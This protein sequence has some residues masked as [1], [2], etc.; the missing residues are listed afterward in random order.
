VTRDDDFIGQLEGYLDDFEGMTPLPERVRNAIRAHLP[1]TQQVGSLPGAVR[2]LIMNMS[3]LRRARYALVA[4]AVVAAAVLGTTLLDRNSG[5]PAISTATPLPVATPGEVIWGARLAAGTYQCVNR[6]AGFAYPSCTRGGPSDYR[7][8]T[9]TVPEGWATRDGFIFKHLGE[10]SEVA[11]SFWSPHKVYAD[12]CHWQESGIEY[13]DLISTLQHQP[14]RAPSSLTTV[15]IF[16][17]GYT[18][19]RLELSVPADL[20]IATCDG[21]EYRSWAES[22]ISTT[23]DERANSHHAA[24]PVDVLYLVGADRGTLIIDASH[25]SA[26]S[27][28]D[29]AELQAIL[30]SIVIA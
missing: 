5:A 28:K 26:A 15:Q 2:Y 21:G 27:E 14:G 9:F 3:M 11:L 20:D 10:A 30:D 8:I 13:G 25:R 24:G 17:V 18:T 23:V 1:M 12:P 6:T 7:T 16:D 29:L 19:D 22:F 4:A